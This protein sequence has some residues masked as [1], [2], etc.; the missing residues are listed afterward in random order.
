MAIFKRLHK[1]L[2][3]TARH[4]Q[5]TKSY[6]WIPGHL[7]YRENKNVHIQQIKQVTKVPLSP[8]SMTVSSSSLFIHYWSVKQSANKAFLKPHFKVNQLS[9]TNLVDPEA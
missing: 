2:L 1:E 5:E 7:F 9:D 6:G 4:W 3:Q 8:Q